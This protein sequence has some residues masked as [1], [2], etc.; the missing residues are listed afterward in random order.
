MGSAIAAFLHYRQDRDAIQNQ[1][2]AFRNISLGKSQNKVLIGPAMKTLQLLNP[3]HF[4]TPAEFIKD[5]RQTVTFVAK[6]H[7]CPIFKWRLDNAQCRE[8]P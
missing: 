7:P 2:I 8:I 5:A 4:C 3:D 1:L 6:E